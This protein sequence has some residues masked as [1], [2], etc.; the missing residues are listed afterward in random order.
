MIMILLFVI[1]LPGDQENQ[2]LSQSQSDISKTKGEGVQFRIFL[3]TAEDERRKLR[4]SRGS[5]VILDQENVDFPSSPLSSPVS[6][7]NTVSF[8]VN[9]WSLTQV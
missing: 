2:T 7:V 9:M 8:I 1:E 5:N 4:R 6:T 3:T